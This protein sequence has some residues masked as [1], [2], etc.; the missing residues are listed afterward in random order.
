MAGQKMIHISSDD[1]SVQVV[2][3]KDITP[4]M[5]H[6]IE[7]LSNSV[8]NNN[9]CHN[10]RGYIATINISLHLLEKITPPDATARFQKLKDQI[11]DLSRILEN[12]I[13]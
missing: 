9:L 11:D 13:E 7:K 5:M 12:I 10:L 3:E 4:E 2:T 6:C 8:V 1:I